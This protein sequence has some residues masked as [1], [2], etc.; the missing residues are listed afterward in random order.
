MQIGWP[1]GMPLVKKLA[2]HLWEIRIHLHQRIARVLFTVRDGEM[3][4]L[5][6][7]IQKSQAHGVRY[8]EET[9]RQRL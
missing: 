5:H 3:V 1:L 9:R 7:F 8:D 6:G 4:L 2:K